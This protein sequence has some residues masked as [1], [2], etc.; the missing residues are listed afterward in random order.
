L[1]SLTVV[2][3]REYALITDSG[4]RFL[5]LP[6][7]FLDLGAAFCT[8]GGDGD[9]AATFCCIGGETDGF[10][11]RPPRIIRLGFG[12]DFNLTG[13]LS[14]SSANGLSDGGDGESLIEYE[15]KETTE[16]AERRGVVG[17]FGLNGLGLGVKH[18]SDRE[19][20]GRIL[21]ILMT[22]LSDLQNGNDLL[23]QCA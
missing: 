23:Y 13:V 1:A 6:F 10:R 12:G 18:M 2:R 20:S 14:S 21:L 22:S 4:L 8:S 3:R 15:T 11:L 16:K 17:S 7:N 19:L 9:A 5:F